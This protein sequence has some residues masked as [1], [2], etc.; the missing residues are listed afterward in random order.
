MANNQGNFLINAIY[1][2]PQELK[3]EFDVRGLMPQGSISE[4]VERLNGIWRNE[5]NNGTTPL[6][7]QPWMSHTQT[8]GMVRIAID[9]IWESP[10]DSYN[11]PQ[12]WTR[13][14]AN[15]WRFQRVELLLNPDSVAMYSVNQRMETMRRQFFAEFTRLPRE[16]NRLRR[17]SERGAQRREDHRMAILRQRPVPT[18]LMLE[19]APSGTVQIEELPREEQGRAEATGNAEEVAVVVNVMEGE[20]A[21]ENIDAQEAVAQVQA[22]EV[23]DVCLDQPPSIDPYRPNDEEVIIDA[24]IPPVEEEQPVVNVIEEGSEEDGSEDGN[25]AGGERCFM[26][27]TNEPNAI[28]V[29][30]GHLHVCFVCGEGWQR[31][32]RQCTFCRERTVSLSKVNRVGGD[33]Q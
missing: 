17:R 19:A 28:F 31:R 30:C 27:E 15:F 5:E 6:R 21:T 1:L 4:Q 14:Y 33:E 8:A 16:Y 3:Y 9:E 13:F 2:T 22:M 23:G 18:Q 32:R 24:A 12:R 7:E 20:N 11:L 10:Q 25:A 29:P 26:C